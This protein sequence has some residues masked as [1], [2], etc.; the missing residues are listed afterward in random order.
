[1]RIIVDRIEENLAVIE[2]PS[3]KT[4]TVDKELIMNAKEGDAIVLSV[5]EKTEQ[6]K[7]DTHSIFEALRKKSKN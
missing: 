4:V 2:L 5:E 7:A 3:G 1:M 6:N